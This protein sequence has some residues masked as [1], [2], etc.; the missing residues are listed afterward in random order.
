L[1]Q[2]GIQLVFAEDERPG[3]D[4]PKRFGLLSRFDEVFSH[5]RQVWTPM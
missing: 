5:T 3:E 1:H 2:A 4:K